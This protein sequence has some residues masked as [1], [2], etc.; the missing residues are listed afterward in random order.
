[1]GK[2]KKILKLAVIGNAGDRYVF[3]RTSICFG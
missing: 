3:G 2:L 1:M